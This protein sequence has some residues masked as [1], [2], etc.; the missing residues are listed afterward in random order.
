MSED[1]KLAHMI[2]ELGSTVDRWRPVVQ[3]ART[4]MEGLTEEDFDGPYIKGRDLLRAVRAAAED[5]GKEAKNIRARPGTLLS[6]RDARLRTSI[7]TLA[8]EYENYRI[9]A[10]QLDCPTETLVYRNVVAAL[11]NALEAI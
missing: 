7:E 6:P 1:G 10:E 3:T 4:Y 2:E 8:A 9:G 5:L 11:K